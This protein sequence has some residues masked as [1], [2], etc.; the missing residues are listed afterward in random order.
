MYVGMFIRVKV[1]PER[2]EALDFLEWAEVT[3]SFELFGE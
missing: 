3:G 2:P 1:R